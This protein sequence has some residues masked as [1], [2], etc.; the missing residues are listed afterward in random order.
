MFLDWDV[1]CSTSSRSQRVG[2]AQQTSST[3]SQVYHWLVALAPLLSKISL[4]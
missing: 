3:T 4:I 2:G 1:V